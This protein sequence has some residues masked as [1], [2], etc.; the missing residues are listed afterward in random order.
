MGVRSGAGGP[1]RV[2]VRHEHGHGRR[3][4]RRTERRGRPPRATAVGVGST[5]GAV[6]AGAVGLPPAGAVADPEHALPALL[7]GHQLIKY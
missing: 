2:E 1:S 5:R 4:G 7:R 3:P 6:P